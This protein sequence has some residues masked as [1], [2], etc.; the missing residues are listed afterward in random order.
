MLDSQLG[1]ILGDALAPD[2]VDVIADRSGG[3]AYLVEELAGVVR[4]DGDPADLPPSLKDVLLSRVDALSA[5]A[6]RLLRTASVAGRAVADRLLAEVAGVARAELFAALRETVENHLLVIDPDGHGYQFRHALTRDAVYEDLLPGERV[7]LHAAYAEVLSRE[8]SLAVDEAA[9]PAMLAYHWYAALDLPRALPAV[10]D[11]AT[12]AAASY[13]PAEELRHLERALEMWPRVPDAQQRT[14][15]DHIEICR[16]AAD[17]AYRS[18]ALHRAR[19]L[20][21]STVAQLQPGKDPERQALLLWQHALAQIELGALGPA[22]ETLREAL[23][24]LPADEVTRTHAV[25][26]TDLARAHGRA[27]ALA[28]TLDAARRAVG[29]A[30][31]AQAPDVEAEAAVTLGA[32]HFILRPAEHDVG[33]DMIRAGLRLALDLD[34]PSAALRGYTNLSEGLNNLGRYAEAEPVAAE[35]FELAVRAGMARMYGCAVAINQADSLLYLGRWEQAQHV[36]VRAL[37][38]RPEGRLAAHLRQLLA[39]LAAMRGRYDE[40]D[41]ELRTALGHISDMADYQFAQP[42]RYTTA[43]IALGRGDLAAARDAIGAGMWLPGSDQVQGAR[44]TWPLVWLGMRA[45]ADEATRL[46]ARRG[47]VPDQ[48]TAHCAELA[49]FATE[50]SA[51]S[52]LP[53]L[54]AYRSLV[55]A[56]HARVG[57]ADDADLWAAVVAAWRTADRPYQVSYALTRLAEVAAASGDRD[58][59]ATALRE[60]HAIAERLGAAPIAEAAATLARR[61]RVSLDTAAGPDPEDGLSRFGLSDREREVLRLVAGGHTNREIATTLFISPKTASVHVSNILAKLG[62][63]DRVAA[64]AVAHRLAATAERADTGRG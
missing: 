40:A 4:A 33:L 56:E 22:A 21:A 46:L 45:E 24:L 14:G 26:L 1:A 6:Q 3:N 50:L 5:D 41:R 55:A 53:A 34:I 7:E 12:R 63:G 47:E 39:E 59:T 52:Q 38:G 43:L 17:A 51:P 16:L 57:A 58:R 62:V 20:L 15:L 30:R 9:R 44:Y 19:S 42:V 49:R 2:L 31:A 60:A 10:I 18:G 37:A 36:I 32:A 8:P 61:A 23:A 29:A 25:V 64:A 54:T 13:A 48:I 27:N 28:E 11:A 35:G